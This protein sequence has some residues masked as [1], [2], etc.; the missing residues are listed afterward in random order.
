MTTDVVRSFKPDPKMMGRAL[1]E[2]QRHGFTTSAKGRVTA[3][4]R[5]KRRD[6][7]KAFGTQLTRHEVSTAPPEIRAKGGSATRSFYF[8]AEKA[9]WNPN[10]DIKSL[11]DD[12]YIQWPHTV[13][14]QRFPVPPPSPLPPR[15]RYHHLRVPGDPA[16]L[17]NAARVH[18]RGFTGRG[19]RVAMIDTGFEHTHPYFTENGYTSAVTLAPGATHVNRDG[20][21]HGTGESA[22]VFSLAPDATFI[23]IKVDNENDPSAGASVLEG[24]QEALNHNPQIITVSLAYDLVASG[25]TR[26]HLTTL[27][28]SLVALETEIENAVAD[29]IVVLFAAGNGHVAFPGMMP[30]VISVGGV[31]IGADGAMQAS[32]YASS[33]NSRIYPGRSVPDVCG[34]VG[35]AQNSADYIMLPI[36]SGCEIDR[37]NAS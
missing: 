18:R 37:G 30:D 19:V 7:E 32:N 5:A 11:I 15:V 35:M 14:N 34:L 9:A 17:L 26:P 8:P 24:F 25:P 31:F 16:M 28:N 20:S 13:L 12:A 33:F 2:M 29:G 4:L 3:S 36:P 10:P 6:Y 1:E 27:P 22:N 21:G 23:G